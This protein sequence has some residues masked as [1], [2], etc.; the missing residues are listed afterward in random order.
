[1]IPDMAAASAQAA[2]FSSYLALA[3]VM[4]FLSLL[5]PCVFPMVPITVSYFTARAG[6]TRREA[7]TQAL[8]YGAG[9]VLTFSAV[10]LALAIFLGAY[11]KPHIRR[12]L[13]HL[14]VVLLAMDG[15]WDLRTTN[16]DA[17]PMSLSHDTEPKRPSRSRHQPCWR[18]VRCKS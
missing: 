18:T 6:R 14:H 11:F 17:S 13:L 5:T 9:I 15:Q 4:G 12:S 16:I 7:V 8:V 1:M 2:S 10:G 3:A